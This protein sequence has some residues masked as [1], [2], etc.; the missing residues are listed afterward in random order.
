MVLHHAL[1]LVRV[2]RLERGQDACVVAARRCRPSCGTNSKYRT[3]R[4]RDRSR[5]TDANRRE[6]PAW[7]MIR[8]NSWFQLR[9]VLGVGGGDER[10]VDAAQVR[11]LLVAERG[12]GATAGEAGDEPEDAV[13]VDDVGPLEAGDECTAPRHR[14]DEALLRELDERLAHRQRG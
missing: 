4:L 13:V 12:G 10:L 8:W 9:L 1:G 7:L 2:V 11:E 3:G 6:P 5:S 14:V